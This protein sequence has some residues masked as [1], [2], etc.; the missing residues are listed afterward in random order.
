MTGSGF[1]RLVGGV[2]AALAATVGLA[3]ISELPAAAAPT[4]TVSPNTDLVDQQVV[5]V[6]VSGLVP[7]VR[8]L[9]TECPTDR[10]YCDDAIIVFL[11]ADGEGR[12]QAEVEV[13]NH[14]FTGQSCIPAGCI[15]LLGGQPPG[16][17]VEF[18]E[19]PL[20]F[21]IPEVRAEV[22]LGA[23]RVGKAFVTFRLSI[24]TSQ[25][26]IVRYRTRSGTA[27]AGEDFV[28]KVDR[29]VIEPGA[30]TA[31]AVVDVIDDQQAE[32]LEFFRV[33]I[34]RALNA[35]VSLSSARSQ[36]LVVDDD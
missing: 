3:V 6:D 19:A 27:M 15:L 8:Y 13:R 31:T 29:V 12:A 26:V 28:T 32:P 1:R 30:L 17:P 33:R 4:L 20:Q 14:L 11:T 16:G 10:A 5:G 23:E 2:L 25:P 18:A 22:G 9:L 24:Q 34:R 36:V 35:T 21:R 7:G